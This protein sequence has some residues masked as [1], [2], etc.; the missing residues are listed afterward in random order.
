MSRELTTAVA[1]YEQELGIRP[2]T[3]CAYDVEAECVINLCDNAVLSAYNIEPADRFCA[4]KSM[5]LVHKQR[6]VTW[7]IFDR[8]MAEGAVGVLVPSARATGGTNLVLWH[9]NGSAQ[10]TV[11]V[12]D[13]LHD[14]PDRPAL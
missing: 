6:P 4:W 3:F 11:R 1:E 13:P 2:G 10:C 9:W 7:D 12:L 8:L 5:V 14:L